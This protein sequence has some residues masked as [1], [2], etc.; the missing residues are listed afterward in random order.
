MASE[1]E[2]GR[3]PRSRGREKADPHASKAE[4]ERLFRERQRTFFQ[5]LR[6]RPLDL[7]VPDDEALYEPLHEG[8]DDP[9]V[10]LLDTIDFS[11]G[12]SVQLVAGFRGTGKTTEFSRLEKMLWNQD[13]L[14]IR[15][16]LDDYLDLHSPVDVVDFLLVLSAAISDRLKSDRLLAEKAGEWD[17]WERAR[18]VLGLQIE[19]TGFKA[20]GAEL[21][22]GMKDDPTVRERV[23]EALAGRLPRLVAEVRAHHEGI[24]A[25]LREKWGADARLVVIVDSLEHIRGTLDSRREV[26]A[27]VQELFLGHARHLQLPATHMVL[28]VPAFLALQADN[29]AAQFVNGAVQAWTSARVVRRDGTPDPEIVDR[30]VR[31]VE[32]RGD[33][34]MVLPDRE[35]LERVILASGGYLRDLLNMLVEG[36]HLAGRV[37]QSE[38]ADRV[39]ATAR[40]SYQ[41]LY[42]DEIDLLRR[43]AEAKDLGAVRIDER[44]YLLRFLDAHLVLC[45]LDAEGF[46]YDVHPLVRDLLKDDGA[47]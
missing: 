42:K 11:V 44:S 37:N 28:S 25:A 14:V 30:L 6:D 5:A 41:P 46:W 15:V 2:R 20:A 43:I 12:E 36:V 3:P 38:V 19:L 8:V 35:A 31:L 33:W 40:R 27:S 26:Y 4:A 23:R 24:L 32:R 34:R 16:D 13:Y 17:F 39:V 1:D 47:V 18:K 45:Y 10:R 21:S 22:I 29:L 7:E 9:V